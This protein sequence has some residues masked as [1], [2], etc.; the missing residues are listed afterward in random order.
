MAAWRGSG[1][2]DLSPGVTSQAHNTD[3]EGATLSDLV[4]QCNVSQILGLGCLN[5]RVR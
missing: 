4:A 5:G 1:T 2:M 3:K